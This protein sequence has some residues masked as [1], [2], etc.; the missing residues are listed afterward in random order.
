MGFTF[1]LHT[2]KDGPLLLMRQVYSVRDEF[3][4]LIPRVTAAEIEGI[5]ISLKRYNIR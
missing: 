1:H 5:V 4:S 3:I 2:M